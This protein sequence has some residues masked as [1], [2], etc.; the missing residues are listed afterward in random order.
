MKL[1]KVFHKAQAPQPRIARLLLLCAFFAAGIMGGQLAP[2]GTAG[3]EL[4]EYARGLAALATENSMVAALPSVAAAYLREPVLLFL[5]SFCGFGAAVIPLVCAWQGFALSFAVACLAKSLG[6][7]GFFLSLAVF[8]IRGAIL[9]PCTLLVAQ[10]ALDRSLS[11]LRRQKTDEDTAFWRRRLA[12][13]LILLLAGVA[14][15]AMLVPKLFSLALR[16]II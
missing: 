9:L 12:V 15:E 16:R 8:G 7:E 1:R 4:A 14:L 11:R 3:E 5:L 2:R 10:W 6:Q 13:C